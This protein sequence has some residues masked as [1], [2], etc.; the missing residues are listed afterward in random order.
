[1]TRRTLRLVALTAVLALTSAACGVFGSDGLT[2]QA[3]FDDVN[4][5]VTQAH[6]RSGDVPIGTVTD[7]ELTEDHR[8]RVTMEV[9]RDT[10]LPGDVRALLAKT[11]V[12]GER[13]IELRPQSDTGSLEDGQVIT[14]TRVIN[15][16]EDLVATGNE[17]LTFVAADRLQSMVETGAV[18]FGGRGSMLGSFVQDFQTFV[19]SYEEDSRAL[20]DLIDGLD[21][22][23][24]GLASQ[25]ETNAES[26]AVLERASRALEDE[27]ERL[28]DMLDEL[29]RL[30]VVG[31]RIMEEHRTETDNFVRRLRKILA[32]VTRVDG[33]LQ[34]LLTWLPAHNL[35]VP[36]AVLN[37]EAQVFLDF[38]VC[39]FDDDEGD[40]SADCDPPNPGEANEPPDR[41]LDED[42]CNFDHSECEGDP[43]PQGGPR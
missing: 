13:F 17:L 43:N 7:I 38:R 6:V 24:G 2:V 18:A 35:H 23:T 22:L 32:Q 5:L 33:A 26:L 16:F 37:E 14:D 10:G 40:P 39:G 8:A 34:N 28:L 21:E 1:M 29:R 41:S 3:T 19:S 42:P 36:N 4:D 25:A 20:T 12:L 9:E 11:S 15:D 27:D 31:E 30:S